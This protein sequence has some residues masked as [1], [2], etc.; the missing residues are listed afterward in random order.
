MRS[1]GFNQ[2]DIEYL[3][4]TGLPTMDRQEAVDQ[5]N[6]LQNQQKAKVMRDR[7]IIEANLRKKNAQKQAIDFEMDRIGDIRD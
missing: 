6:S 4:K 2:V 3:I 7:A 5:L 1:L